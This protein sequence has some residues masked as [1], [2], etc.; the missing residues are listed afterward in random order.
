[1]VTKTKGCNLLE[2]GLKSFFLVK[3][4]SFFY[5][6]LKIQKKKTPPEK[7]GFVNGLTPWLHE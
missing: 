3:F 7:T 4:I 1:M 2:N 5:T 6:D